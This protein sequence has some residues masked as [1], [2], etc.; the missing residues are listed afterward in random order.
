ML[1]QNINVNLWINGR[2]PL[3]YAAD[4]GQ[5]EV[6]RYLLDKGADANVRQSH[7]IP[8]SVP[9]LQYFQCLIH[10]VRFAG[11]RQARHNHTLGSY[12]GRPYQ[13]C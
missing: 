7:Y 11:H 1:L 6:V 2:T 3:H 5:N 4:Y 8:P 10:A 12:M 13:L 9:C